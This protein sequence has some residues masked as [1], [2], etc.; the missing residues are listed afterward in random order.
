MRKSILTAI[1]FV[2]NTYMFVLSFG[3]YANCLVNYLNK[4]AYL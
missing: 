2:N 1:T 3:K 4:S